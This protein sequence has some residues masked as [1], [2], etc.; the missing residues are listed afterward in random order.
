MGETEIIDELRVIVSEEGRT[1]AYF[2]FSS[3]MQ[4]LAPSIP[5]LWPKNGL[6]LNQDHETLIK[7]RGAPFKSYAEKFV[8]P[9]ALAGQYLRE[10]SHES[11][12]FSWRMT[13]T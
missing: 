2:T 7:L 10:Y 1:T 13:S 4:S 11:A 9:V 3:Q 8:P 6:I 12:H 5:H